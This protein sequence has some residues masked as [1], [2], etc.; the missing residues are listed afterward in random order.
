VR[1]NYI[2]WRVVALHRDVDSR[3]PVHL[4]NDG[5]FLGEWA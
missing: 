3:T 4:P 2:R 1:A 5:G